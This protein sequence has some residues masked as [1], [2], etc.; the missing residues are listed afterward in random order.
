MRL[1]FSREVR[2][3][4][5]DE[6]KRISTF[7]G[8]GLGVLGYSMTI[9]LI[10]LGA[11]VWWTICQIIAS[12]LLAIEDYSHDDANGCF[13]GDGPDRAICRDHPSFRSMAS[14]KSRA[15]ENSPSALTR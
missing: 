12:I 8:I 4:I 9:P 15:D 1:K 11:F 5:A 2:K 10:V 13:F 3:S 6:L 14:E 7:G